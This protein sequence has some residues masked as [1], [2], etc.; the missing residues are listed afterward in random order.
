MASVQ[1]EETVR[2]PAVQ[3]RWRSLTFLHVAY[4]PEVVAQLLPDGLEPDLFDGR[5]WVGITPFKM[6]SS[7]LPLASGPRVPV[8]EVNVRTYVRDARGR[9]ALWFL[10]LELDQLAVAAALRSTI[11]IPYRWAEVSVERDGPMV[12]YRAR[13][14]PPHRA[15]SFALEVE[16]GDAADDAGELEAFLTGRW[17]AFTRVAGRTLAVPVQHEPWPLRH[18]RLVSWEGDLLESVGL[19]PAEGA[20][21]LLFSPGV[22]ARLGWP[23]P[24]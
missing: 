17:R 16:V 4:P 9:D 23:R 15:G 11:Q 19:P 6:W 1:P 18:A 8:G 20:P 21:H 14:R 7:V 2:V 13:R 3:Q 22:D 24:A 12:R 10:S 5:A